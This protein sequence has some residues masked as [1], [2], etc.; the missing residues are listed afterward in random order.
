MKKILTIFLALMLSLSCIGLV[1]C[2]SQ[3][4]MQSTLDMYIFDQE[5]QTLSEDFVLPGYIGNYKATWT[6]DNEIISLTEI[7]KDAENGIERQYLAQVGLP[8]ERQTVNLTV[9]ITKLITKTFT[10]YVNPLDVYNF[11]GSYNFI[12]NNGTVV[13]DFAL[14][15]TCE[16]KGHVATIE[17]SVPEEFADYLAISED[18]KTCIVYPSSLNPKVKINA[19]FTYDGKSTTKGYS[20]T[21]SEQ[22]EPLQ[23]VDYWYTNT[24]VGIVMSGYVVSIATVYSESYQN[25]S[26]YMINDEF[27]AGYYLYRVKTDSANAALLAPGVHITVTGTTNTDYNGLMETNAGGKLVVDGDIPAINVNEKVYAIDNDIIGDLQTAYYNQARL[28]SLS[29]WTVK[30]IKGTPDLSSGTQTL[31]VLTK[32]GADVPVVISKY[33]EGAYAYKADDATC[34]A[35]IGLQS[36]LKVG[37]VVSVTG[38]LGNYKGHQIAPLTAE[39][40]VVGGTADAE[41]TVYAGQKA[42]KAI[43]AIDKLFEENGL[44]GVIAANKSVVLPADVESCAVE[45]RIIGNPR[46]MSIAEGALVINPGKIEK[47]CLTANVTV[48]GFTTTIFRYLTAVEL[49]DAG[50]VGMEA[51][52]FAL[53]I[54]PNAELSKNTTVE[55]PANGSIFEE[56]AIT[57][58]L[59]GEAVSGS[60]EF[61]Q[62]VKEAT[63]TLVGTLA[64]NNA[65]ETLTY[66]VKVAAKPAKEM[67]VVE[68][69]VVGTAYKFGVNQVTLGET[70][71]VTGAQE[72]DRYLVTTNDAEAAPDVYVEEA[73]G[74]IKIYVLDGS[75][76]KYLHVYMN[77]A[78]QTALA[79]DANNASVFTYDATTK[80]YV[81]DLQGTPYYPG[82]YNNFN[83][84]SASKTSYINADNTGVTQF[85]ANFY[86]EK[87][88]G[89]E[90]EPPVEDKPLVEGKGYAMYLNQ[91]SN[92]TTLYFNGQTESASVNYRLATT[93]NKAEAV[94]VYVEYVANGFHLYFNSAE[95]VKTYIRV[96]ERT[97]GDAGYGKG[98]LEFTT[99]VPAEV[100]T[101]DETL[102]LPVVTSADGLNQ[103]YMGTYSNF[104]TMS[105]SN[106]SYITGKNA[107]NLRVTQ[108]PVEFELIEGG[109]VEPPVED[110]P[111]VEGKGYAMY[112]NQLSN[113]TTLYFNGQTES[114]SVNYRLA[115][116]ENKAEAVAVYVEYVANGFH[117]YFN[118][119]EGVKTYIRV[120]ERTAGDAGY[121]KG[122]L[123]FTTSVP[124]EVYTWDETLGLPVVTSADGLNQY[125]MG[126]YSNFVTMSV[127]NTSYITGK[128][129]ANLRVTQYP[130][131]FELIEGSE[132]P[133]QPEQP[134]QPDLSTPE[135]IVKAAYALEAGASLGTQT[136]TGV[137]T[138]FTEYSASYNNLTVTIVVDGLTDYPIV[139]FRI[140]GDA[141]A[142][143]KLGDT[144]TVTGDIIN[145][146]GTIEFN[147][148]SSLDAWVAGE[149][150]EEPEQPEEPEV[151]A[152]EQATITF[153]DTANRT[154]FTTEQ[155]VWVMNG[156][157]VTNDKASSKSNVADYSNP[158]RF[159]AGSNVTISAE[160]NIAKIVITT[161][162]GKN[163]SAAPSIEGCTV[164]VD[165]TVCTIVVEGEANSV[166]IEALAAQVRVSSIV[167]TFAAASEPEQPEQP[168][169]PGALN[170]VAQYTAGTTSK[171]IPNANNAATLGLSPVVFNVNTN[172]VSSYN[173]PIG[174]NEDGGIRLYANNYD[175]SELTFTIAN[176]SILGLTITLLESSDITAYAVL[177]NGVEVVGEN[178]VYVIAEGATT[179]V[180]KNN[181]EKGQLH[182][183]KI[184]IAYNV[185]AEGHTCEYGAEWSYSDTTHFHACECGQ[186]ADEAYHVGGTATTTEQAVCEVCA[187]PY[188]KLAANVMTIAEV[189]ASAE[190]TM[191][192]FTGRVTIYN[193]SYSGTTIVVEDETGSI[194]VFK[195]D[196]E[197]NVYDIVTV[198]GVRSSYNGTIQIEEGVV[199][200]VTAHEHTY[201]A[202]TTDDR[203]HWHECECGEIVDVAPHV[204]GADGK[205]ECGATVEA[206]AAVS[207]VV[208]EDV[209]QLTDG[210]VII[211]TANGNAMGAYNASSNIFTISEVAFDA[212]ATALD[213][214][215]YT[216][217]L[218]KDGES[219]LVKYGNEYLGW[220]TGNKAHLSESVTDAYRWNITVENGALIM[221]NVG[222]PARVIQYNAGSP[223]FVAYQSSQVKPVAYLV[224]EEEVEEPEVPV[225][226]VEAT[227]ALAVTAA[228]GTLAAD[229]LSISWTNDVV[230][231]TAEKG[232]QNN[233]IRT[234][235]TDH[236][237]VYQGNVATFSVANGTIKQIVITCT[238]GSYATVCT[239][240]LTEAG[241]TAVADGNVVTVTV[242]GASSITF[243]ASAQWRF[244]N[245][246]VTYVA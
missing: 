75:T 118:S 71:Y 142:N 88:Q 163:F 18:G 178:G 190:G 99:S 170:V 229:S 20:M 133:E 169:I 15:S 108:Y 111:L 151:P 112:L 188:G 37:D 97:A 134:E 83:T 127:S 27:T 233:A 48:D 232:T 193:F 172:T 129:A 221:S 31:F 246:E 110:K 62:G 235:D 30:E 67:V 197:V 32:G 81:T 39:S 180:V 182:I 60:V 105:V 87:G 153:E 227:S 222:T 74:G 206:P 93:E 114:A 128:N 24:G 53:S 152:G 66:T 100:Y 216:F 192:S 64:L 59:D 173:N 204:A 70:L 10:V 42:A 226:P 34:S 5:G 80:A 102:G 131:E 21:V 40:I 160:K 73:T 6:S 231:F 148:G 8:E 7:P 135:K 245:V 230:T 77:D 187:Q 196:G 121:G 154:V 47:V 219:W 217:T 25:V 200:V 1:A 144:I 149:G 4:N 215:W 157:T 240:S 23:E 224:I 119:A 167:V 186:R 41:G 184:E 54:E 115:T 210:A 58:T 68:N 239:N 225:A 36:T 120:Y 51:E 78:S 244:N 57:W 35:L 162:G 220:E 13:S 195:F 22:K 11:S 86:G 211:L 101:W 44:D 189:I 171:L 164:T 55:L 177:V 116:T 3:D 103:Y 104:V 96:Y 147:S 69:P 9:A 207:F 140:K 175:G 238:S 56:I 33:Y 214:T 106:T 156:I 43:A 166:T 139:C 179:V 45:Y 181:Q 228:T 50:K 95:G 243:S 126:T 199:V 234:S 12:N 176:G 92:G 52:N 91:L 72:R 49:D 63:Y 125:Y 143:V 85:P 208:V 223:R 124:A 205:C 90:V 65:V 185:T 209:A 109:E 137:V 159:Y 2:G 29:N 117:L 218:V 14:D 138:V 203:N 183:A 237:R 241:Y 132:E 130:V 236:F 19:T 201:G 38:I 123:E 165:G 84:L 136:L 145:Y 26:L 198:T 242:E 28:V 16:F 46:S 194:Q 202:W 107:A 79:F 98:S 17:W 141:I 155:Q 158:A 213:I 122:S 174:V 94:A 61:K 89:G 150:S 113:G 146:N 212:T 76:K 191:V 161:A 168:E 82:A